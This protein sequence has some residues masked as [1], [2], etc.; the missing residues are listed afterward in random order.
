MC[1]HDIIIALISVVI[2]VI[3][4][5]SICTYAGQAEREPQSTAVP[6]L[7]VLCRSREQAPGTNS[8]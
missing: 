3:T 4:I 6:E 8:K 1:K 7:T 5:L 2:I